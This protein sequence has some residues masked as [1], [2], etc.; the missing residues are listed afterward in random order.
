[1]L[2]K[3]HTFKPI[4]IL[5]ST[6]QIDYLVWIKLFKLRCKLVMTYYENI[7]LPEE[8]LNKHNFCLHLHDVCLSIFFECMEEENLKGI[9]IR[10]QDEKN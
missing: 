6:S 1:M 5:V 3:Q 10:E 8:Y 9:T 2:K 7:V 4:I